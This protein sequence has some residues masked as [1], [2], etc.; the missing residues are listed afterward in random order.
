MRAGCGALLFGVEYINDGLGTAAFTHTVYDFL[1]F[2]FVLLSWPVE[3]VTDTP[4][5][6]LMSEK[7]EA[8]KEA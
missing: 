5:L 3:G 1:A 7:K 4:V 6:E 8:D 2:S